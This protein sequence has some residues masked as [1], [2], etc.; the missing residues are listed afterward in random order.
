LRRHEYTVDVLGNAPGLNY[1]SDYRNV[2]GV[3]VPTKRRVFAYDG[4]KRKIPEPL[5]VAIDIREAARFF[6]RRAVFFLSGLNKTQK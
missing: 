2:S 1:A 5:R 6:R 3:E 4:E